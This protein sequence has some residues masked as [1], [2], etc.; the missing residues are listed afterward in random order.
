MSVF[1]FNQKPAYERRISDWSSDVCSSDLGDVPA[2]SIVLQPGTSSPLDV[3]G[4]FGGVPVALAG[5]MTVERDRDGG[6]E[7]IALD[8]LGASY[9]VIETTGTAA[10][11]LGDT[12]PRL[13][14]DLAAE[15]IDVGGLVGDGGDEDGDPLDQIGRA[16]V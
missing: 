15:E 8:K 6:V 5:D 2:L 9:G 12:G 7:R 4:T 14:A 1:F 13:V 11:S 10:L 3:K 16:H